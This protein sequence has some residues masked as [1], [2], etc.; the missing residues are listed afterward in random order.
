MAHRCLFLS[1]LID[2][3][4][5]DNFIVENTKKEDHSTGLSTCHSENFWEAKGEADPT[6]ELNFVLGFSFKRLAFT[7]IH[8]VGKVRR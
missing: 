2:K 7:K 5:N 4:G 8:G 1:Y 6:L 3:Y